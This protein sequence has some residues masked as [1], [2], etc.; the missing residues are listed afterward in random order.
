VVVAVVVKEDCG[1]CCLP[2]LQPLT[3]GLQDNSFTG[4]LPV[5]GQNLKLVALR[6]RGNGFSGTI[7]EDLWNVPLLMT[8]DLTNNRYDIRYRQAAV[9]RSSTQK[10][11]VS[12]AG[13][14]RCSSSSSSVYSS[15]GCCKK[16][17]A[18]FCEP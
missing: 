2:S 18:I 7:P 9:S 12:A 5:D 6:A 16:A 3:S 10:K 8:V 14:L 1:V 4:S 11:D 17:A 15:V 13:M